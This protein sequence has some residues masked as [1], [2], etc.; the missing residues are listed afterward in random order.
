M[1]TEVRRLEIRARRRRIAIEIPAP[2]DFQTTPGPTLPEET[3]LRDPSLSL[4]C[5]DPARRVALFVSTRPD[6]RIY[7]EPFL[8]QAQNKHAQYLVSASFDTLDRLGTRAALRIKRIAFLFSV[9]RCGST[10]V[11]R[12]LSVAPGVISLSEPDVYSQLVY[13]RQHDGSRDEEITEIARLCAPFLFGSALDSIELLVVKPRSFG[14]ELAPLLWRAHPQMRAVFMYRNGEEVVASFLRM[15]DGRAGLRIPRGAWAL[16]LWLLLQPSMAQRALYMIPLLHEHPMRDFLPAGLAGPVLAHWV[17]VLHRYHALRDAG[18]PIAA[19]RY[20]D[21]IA[22]TKGLLGTLFAWLELP[23]AAL[24]AA[25]KLMDS[26]SQAGSV[27]ARDPG[28][29]PPA[30]REDERRRIHELVAGFA[31][32][33]TLDVRLPGTLTG[34][35][36]RD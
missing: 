24:A 25:Q 18:L 22:D 28:E 30:L 5:I 1:P 29:D 23:P 8:Y 4:Y 27:L 3:L 9:G 13:L 20:E 36:G 31:K 35:L 21:L 19:L 11:S 15:L 33:G 14:T 2:E 26:D 12:M 16:R 10:L 34:E 6:A 17:S 32:I 7:E